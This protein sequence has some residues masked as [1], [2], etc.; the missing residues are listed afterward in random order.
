MSTP[1]PSPL[2]VAIIGTGRPQMTASGFGM[3]HRHMAGFR[4]SGRCQLAAVA[5]ISRENAEAF[6]AVH[7][8]AAAIYADYREMMATVKPDL[9]SICLWPH[10][11]AEVVEA[12]VPHR[13]RAILCEKPMDIHWD[14]AL[15]M[16]RVSRE[17]GVLLAINHQR[18]FNRPISQ[19]RELLDSGAIGKLLRLEGAWGNLPDAGTHVLDLMF[20][21][22]HDTPADW[23]LGQMD[24]RDSRKIF[25]AINAGHGITEFRFKNGVRA[26][27]RYGRDH[28]EAGCLLRLVGEDGTIEIGFDAPWLRIRWAGQTAWE[29]I[30]TGEHIHDDLAIHRAIAEII[31][32]LEDGHRPQL[33]SENALRATEII[34]ATYESVRRRARID[35]PL[36]PG[37][38][39]MLAMLAAGE[40]K[41]EFVS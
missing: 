23:V 15:R 24:M 20:F 26:I 12:I 36:P 22:N 3:A 40:L 16:D 38:C 1:L 32:S 41:A 11:H 35:L 33:A 2:K 17:H 7:D 5:D 29:I 14:A 8:P 25:G 6:I 31:A 21:F 18:R 4:A 39:A 34:F 19:A 30:D 28:L 10:L 13:P 37:P 27:Y 9:V